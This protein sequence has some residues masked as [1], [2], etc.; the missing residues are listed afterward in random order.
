[1]MALVLTLGCGLGWIVHRAQVQREAVA[2]I[3]RAGGSVMYEH[4]L[5][6]RIRG[7]PWWPRSAAEILGIDYFD[8][9]KSV[10]LE[11]KE[12]D[13]NLRLDET[14]VGDEGMAH[15]AMLT[16]LQILTLNGTAVTD[17]GL[18]SIDGL[19]G[20]ARLADGKGDGSLSWAL[21]M[22]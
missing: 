13:K 5:R 2:A 4:Q 18:R 22:G 14:A 6:P 17:A 1:M 9:V 21:R 8:D 16:G 12:F 3:R 10:F 11:S 7:E 20:L 15:L 19:T